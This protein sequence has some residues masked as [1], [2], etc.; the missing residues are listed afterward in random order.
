KDQIIL[1]TQNSLNNLIEEYGRLEN[2]NESL[3]IE[4]SKKEN[5]N[6]SL[7]ESTKKIQA[8]NLSVEQIES[9]LKNLKKQLND[10]E[11][12]KKLLEDINTTFQSKEIS[13]EDLEKT[14]EVLKSNNLELKKENQKLSI[15]L[16]TGKAEVSRLANFEEEISYLKNNIAELERENE[17][18]KEKDAILLAKTINVMEQENK[19]KITPTDDLEIGEKDLTIKEETI[20]EESKEVIQSAES[21][22]INITDFITSEKVDQIPESAEPEVVSLEEDSPTSSIGGTGYRKKICPNC[23]NYNKAQIREFDDKTRSI[24]PGFYAKKYKCGQCATEWAK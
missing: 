18:L 3:K 17:H 11:K 9:D 4:I 12:E 21:Q 19:E 22:P 1:R 14:I 23:G 7:L 6:L 24:Y 20:L 5:E 13:V 16:D 8:E 10:L 2:T 15:R